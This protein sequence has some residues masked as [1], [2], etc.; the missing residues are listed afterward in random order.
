MRTKFIESMKTK[1]IESNKKVPLSELPAGTAFIYEL[2][3]GYVVFMVLKTSPLTGVIKQSKEREVRIEDCIIYCDLDDGSITCITKGEA[4]ET[5]VYPVQPV[6][7]A[8]E[9]RP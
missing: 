6:N 2:S 4:K 1:F 3:S 9:F 7:G 8:L 5:Y